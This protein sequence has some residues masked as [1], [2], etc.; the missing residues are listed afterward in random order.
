MDEEQIVPRLF[1]WRYLG[2]E[3]KTGVGRTRVL[4]GVEQL[5]GKKKIRGRKC[6]VGKITVTLQFVYFI[7]TGSGS[8]N[9][10]GNLP[11]LLDPLIDLFV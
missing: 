1:W 11:G 5:K 10:P 7:Q 9:P 8:G 4:G 2:G 6:A 3:S